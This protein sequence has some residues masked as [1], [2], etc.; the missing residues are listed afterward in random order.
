M[1]GLPMSWRVGKAMAYVDPRRR[2]DGGTAK[3]SWCEHLEPLAY[4][5]ARYMAKS[6]ARALNKIYGEEQS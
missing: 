1:S 4:E 3:L 5:E 6:W 2:G